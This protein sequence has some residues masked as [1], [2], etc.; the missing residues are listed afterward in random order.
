MSLVEPPSQLLAQLIALESE[1]VRFKTCL[2]VHIPRSS[3][4]VLVLLQIARSAFDSGCPICLEVLCVRAQLSKPGQQGVVFGK[5]PFRQHAGA[6][7][8]THAAVSSCYENEL[9]GC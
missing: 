9:V 1:L 6:S 5:K 4:R 8:R 2:D 7:P 3:E